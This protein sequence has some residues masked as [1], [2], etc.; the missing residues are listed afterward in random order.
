MNKTGLGIFLSLVYFAGVLYLLL[1]SPNTPIL[2]SDLQSDEPGDTWQHPEQK[3]FF[4]NKNR[5]M[6][7][8]EM[9]KNFSVFFGNI[10][11]P[12]YRLNYRPEEVGTLVRDQLRSYYLEEIVYP[13]RESLFVSGWEP[14]NSPIY[15]GYLPKDRPRII[16]NDIEYLS[17]VTIR[18]VRSSSVARLLVW[19]L[20]FPALYLV[21]RSFKSLSYV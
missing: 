12:S 8:L 7:I 10:R 19:T 1:P 11:I 5:S 3:A 18:P 9:Q 2:G 6:V 16:I 17:K 14:Q 15:K 13:M 4:T 21:Y 20:C